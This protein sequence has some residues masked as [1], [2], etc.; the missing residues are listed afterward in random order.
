LRYG[1]GDHQDDAPLAEELEEDRYYVFYQ[2]AGAEVQWAGGP[3]APNLTQAIP[4]AEGVLGGTLRWD[5]AV[6]P[7][8]LRSCQ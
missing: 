5:P 7:V 4:L 8:D 1:T 2:V 6:N 3:S